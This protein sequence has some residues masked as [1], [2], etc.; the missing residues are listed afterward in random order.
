VD[1]IYNPSVFQYNEDVSVNT[2]DPAYIKS[3]SEIWIGSQIYEGLVGLD[4]QQ[5]PVPALAKNWEISK[6]GNV[7]KFVLNSEAQ[8]ISTELAKWGPTKVQTQKITVNDVLYSF[9]RILN[10][11]T[12]SPGAWIFSDKVNV[13][14][15]FDY[16]HWEKASL[17]DSAPFKK[18]NDSTLTI[19]LK[20][21]FPAF[22]SILATNYAWIVPQSTEKFENGKLG[23]SPI[24]TGPFYLKKWEEDVRMV[25][26]K[27][28]HYYVFEGK[29]RLPYLQAVNVDFVKNKQTAFMQFIAKKYDFFNGIDGS[30]KDDLL[31][32]DGKLKSKYKGKI[33]ALITPFL[34]TEY[35]GF[36]LGDSL[37]GK[38]N[39][40]KDKNL[41][42]ALQWSVDRKSLVKY[43]RNGLGVEG[44]GGFVPP[45]LIHQNIQNKEMYQLDVALAF[46]KKSGYLNSKTKFAPLKITVTTDYLDMAVFL[47]QSWAQIGIPVAVDLQ[48]GGMLRQLRNQGKLGMFRGSWI[49]DYP[50]AE[51]YLSCFYT[52]YFSPNGP[53]YTHFSLTA[54]D[55]LFSKI[56]FGTYQNQQDRTLDVAKANQLI[57]EEAPV[58]IM[59]YD[60]SL[61]LMHP[62]VKGLQND[63]SNRL[64]LKRVQK[65]LKN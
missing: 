34:N 63:A 43:L 37:E 23:R 27:N 1:N 59:Y 15:N 41:R 22:L 24:G 8:F 14:Q 20:S 56:A 49:A 60:K 2:L 4:S 57:T 5:N 62:H 46:L 36:Y 6:E 28:P 10:P 54:F 31:S 35:I 42:K 45:T 61:R 53:N 26:L 64:D 30:F 12:A 48:T 44:N 7:Y 9:Y 13:P 50:D 33:N 32:K 17:T 52:N 18:L 39:P 38:L 51:N 19:T 16:H 25:L 40:F 29:N 47:Q 58:L 55:Q 11:E 21:P 65:Q 3:Q